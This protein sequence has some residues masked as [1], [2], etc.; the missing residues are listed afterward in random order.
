VEMQQFYLSNT[1]VRKRT[2]GFVMFFNTIKTIQTLRR[3]RNSSKLDDFKMIK[4]SLA[5]SS[6][7]AMCNGTCVLFER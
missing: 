4:N 3:S 7:Y 1:S 2:W 5:T 6:L